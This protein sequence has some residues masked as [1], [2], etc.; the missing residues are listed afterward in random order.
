M[1]VSNPRKADFYDLHFDCDQRFIYGY[2]MYSVNDDIVE[3]LNNGSI[4]DV[5]KN[6]M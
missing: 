5:Y 6:R 3:R 1:Y 4:I 2:Q